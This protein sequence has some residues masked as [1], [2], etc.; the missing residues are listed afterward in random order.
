MALSSCLRTDGLITRKNAGSISKDLLV[1]IH[2]YLQL[3]ESKNR[4][5][6]GKKKRKKGEKG[7]N[8]RETHF[9]CEDWMNLI[10]EK[11]KGKKWEKRNPRRDFATL[12]KLK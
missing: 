1:C 10:R 2:T 9:S 8:Q 3:D 7:G 11:K 5:K 6:G 12:G 4:G